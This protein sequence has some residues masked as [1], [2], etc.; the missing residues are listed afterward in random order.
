M[1]LVI[2]PNERLPGLLNFYG[3]SKSAPIE[4]VLKGHKNLPED[5]VGLW[6]L[7]QMQLYAA[8]IDVFPYIQAIEAGGLVVPSIPDKSVYEDAFLAQHKET[9]VLME[10]NFAMMEEHVTDMTVELQTAKGVLSA[11]AVDMAELGDDP[12]DGAE[13]SVAWETAMLK[14]QKTLKAAKTAKD[15]AYST[16]STVA[17]NLVKEKTAVAKIKETCRKDAIDQRDADIDA[18]ATLKVALQLLKKAVGN[19]MAKYEKIESCVRQF[20]RDVPDPYNASDMRKVFANLVA[21]YRKGDSMGVLTSM[22]GGIRKIQEEQQPPEQWARVLQEFYHSMRNLG[23]TTITLE[24]FVAMMGITG[25]RPEYRESFLTQQTNLKLTLDSLITEE[26]DSLDDLAS[27]SSTRRMQQKT[28][29]EQFM[30]YCQAEAQRVLYN[31][32]LMKVQ[33]VAPGSTATA[34]AAAAAPTG[35]G[36]LSKHEQAA[37]KAFQVAFSIGQ[38]KPD[39]PSDNKVSES[40]KDTNKQAAFCFNWVRTGNCRKGETCKFRHV[41]RC[42]QWAKDGTCTKDKKCP[43]KD[44]HVSPPQHFNPGAA[45]PTSSALYP[46]TEQS[47][48]SEYNW[49]GA[50]SDEEVEAVIIKSVPKQPYGAA[51][52]HSVSQTPHRTV[53]GW[54][55]HA[56]INVASSL[57]I[58][59][60][61]KQVSSPATPAVL[62]VHVLLLTLA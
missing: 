40:S 62:V 29:Y 45:K 32:R 2:V 49:L 3:N 1:D 12:E 48:K 4:Q 58:I 37:L 53:L 42:L 11:A 57:E 15:A 35:K 47:P 19:M 20:D 30:A 44:S 26:E 6:V 10:S 17:G 25:M 16:W 7:E 21:K 39:P 51:E 56:S 23:V 5:V 36:K 31:L 9:I 60:G 14:K 22:M 46:V 59:P 18:V 43:H 52:V 8:E 33:A 27:R 50:A 41:S 13:G 54:D 24:D 38:A 55:S 28:L 34:T 61:A